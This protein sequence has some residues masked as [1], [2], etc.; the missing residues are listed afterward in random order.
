MC[1][2]LERIFEPRLQEII[3]EAEKKA[4]EEAKKEAQA[5]ARQKSIQL[6][7]ETIQEFQVSFEQAVLKITDKFALQKNEAEHYVKMYW[8]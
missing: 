2:A 3:A 6:L 1:E 7:V 5:E 4:S 8:K